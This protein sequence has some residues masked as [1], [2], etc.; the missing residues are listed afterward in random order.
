[1]QSTLAHKFSGALVVVAAIA[2]I[3]SSP[4]PGGCGSN[5]KQSQPYSTVDESCPGPGCDVCSGGNCGNK[6]GPDNCDDSSGCPCTDGKNDGDY[7][8]AICPSAPTSSQCRY[9][10]QGSYCPSD[11]CSDE[12]PNMQTQPTNNCPSGYPVDCNNGYC[13]PSGTTCCK[14]S[15]WC[16]SDSSACEETD[17]PV[18]SSG[19]GSGCDSSDICSQAGGT[20]S[21]LRQGGCCCDG[22]SCPAPQCFKACVDP[23]T[24]DSWWEVQGQIYTDANSTA[25]AVMQEPGCNF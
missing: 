3:G 10:P 23:C 15:A 22:G 2:L 24:G 8:C 13:C 17:D 7:F 6:S 9:C 16:G 1:M 19:S 25:Q 4:F 14:D 18:G 20:E 5:V 21:T 12:C 11:P